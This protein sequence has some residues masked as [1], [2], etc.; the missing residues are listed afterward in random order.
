ML[1]GGAPVTRVVRRDQRYGVLSQVTGEGRVRLDPAD[2]GERNLPGPWAAGAAG[3]SLH[4]PED[5]ATRPGGTPAQ[6]QLDQSAA[7]LQTAGG[8]RWPWPFAAWP[9]D[10][11][12]LEE[13]WAADAGGCGRAK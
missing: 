7:Q 10:L 11:V 5:G 12:D 6:F 8:G 2:G 9:G 3:C 13:L 4:A 1:D